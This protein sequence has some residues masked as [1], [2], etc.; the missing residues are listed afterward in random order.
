[1]TNTTFHRNGWLSMMAE[2]SLWMISGSLFHHRCRHKS[3]IDEGESVVASLMR[4][5]LE[6][7]CEALMAPS[8]RPTYHLARA[9]SSA[10]DDQWLRESMAQIHS[11]LV[12]SW[13]FLNIPGI[14]GQRG[15]L[16]RGRVSLAVDRIYE[17]DIEAEGRSVSWDGRLWRDHKFL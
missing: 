7:R 10:P 13:K 9:H 6:L 14:T 15:S 5:S 3:W 12:D 4:F 1:M 8:A 11:K 16:V 17:P 2:G